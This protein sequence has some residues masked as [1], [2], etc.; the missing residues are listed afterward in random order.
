MRT[1]EERYKKAVAQLQIAGV[2]VLENYP[3]CCGSCAGYDIG[4]NLGLDGKDVI[5]FINEQNNGLI[6]D[7]EGNPH[8]FDW[9]WTD[10]TLSGRETSL[11]KG[12]YWKHDGPN[13]ARLT[14]EIFRGH[15]FE[16]EWNGSDMQ[17]PYLKFN[18]EE[19]TTPFAV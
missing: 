3:S 11:S 7:S 2:V 13:A 18:A 19:F 9:E 15:G 12:I 6:W 4:T 16:V 17:C 10:N 14:T 5:Y 8:N 1:I